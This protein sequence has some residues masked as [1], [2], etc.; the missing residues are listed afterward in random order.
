MR[1]WDTT[2]NYNN[3]PGPIKKIYKKIYLKN[4]YKYNFWIESISK[5]NKNDYNWWFSVCSS[6][7]ELDTNLYHYFCI[8]ETV[9]YNSNLFKKIILSSSELKKKLQKKFPHITFQ[10]DGFF[11]NTIILLIKNLFL[12]FLKYFFINL[13]IIKKK[14]TNKIVIANN[15]VLSENL[16]YNFYK[17]F[18]AEINIKKIFYIPIFI[19][20]SLKIFFLLI[21]KYYKEKNI[22]FIESF[23][24]YRDIF[25]SFF[26]NFKINKNFLLF[27]GN[28]FTS[29]IKEEI[30]KNRYNISVIQSYLFFF[31]L[32]V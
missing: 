6:R 21:L 7:N 22:I 3:Y 27:N 5:D 11:F 32:K 30:N 29:I 17:K 26:L 4:I 9:N 19:N 16:N 8:T 20:F 28:D 12:F 10:V 31:F 23:L 24:T 1:V 25:K 18:L 13:F 2:K 15:F 14:Y